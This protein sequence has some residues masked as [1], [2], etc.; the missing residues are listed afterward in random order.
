M[1][2]ED[3]YQQESRSARRFGFLLAGLLVAALLS[4]L[5][6]C[7]FGRLAIPGRTVLLAFLA[8]AGLAGPGSLDQTW[9]EVILQIRLS[10]ICLAL[11]VGMALAVAGTAFQGILRNP[12]ADPFTLGVSTGAACGASLA[13]FLGLGAK[14]AWGL[15]LLPLAALAGAVAALGAVLALGR[16][17][18]R[19]RRD[20]MVLAGIVVATFLSAFISLLKSLDEESVSSIVF[21]VMGSFQGRGWSHVLFALPYILTGLVIVG[22]KAR[23]LDL[24]SL[25]EMQARQMGVE[26][27]Q[28]RRLLLIGASLLTAG[29]VA[30]SGI[31]GFVGLV[32]PHL[33]RML[34]GAEHRPLL[35]LSGLLGGLALLWSDVLAR[36]ILPGGEELP[37]GV[38]TAILGGP[39]FC[40]LLKRRREGE[41]IG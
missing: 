10:R 35:I 25:G 31:I 22:L 21:W 23:E 41:G 4:I 13:I 32:V 5:L 1:N 7:M 12:L 3:I 33:L 17:N 36:V 11:L 24:L 19:L 39:F 30:V 38:V 9:Q 18:G 34:I 14:T 8:Q 37:V 26:V 40:L 20:T 15:G 6:A 16:V 28:T 27:D 29:A 2:R